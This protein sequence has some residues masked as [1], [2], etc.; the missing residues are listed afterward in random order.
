MWPTRT[1]LFAR[2][3]VAAALAEAAAQPHRLARRLGTRALVLLGVG[4]VV[5]AGVFSSIGELAAG[6]AHRPGAGPAIVVAYIV[7]AI[8]CGFS[9]MAYAEMASVVP[10]AGSAYTYAYV[11]LGKLPAWIIGW[12]LVIEYAIGNI[13]VAQSWAEYFAVLLRHTLGLQ[14]PVWMTTDMQTAAA[15]A[16]IASVAPHV[17]KV[18]VAFNLPAAFVTGVLTLVLVRGIRG[19]ARL[20][21]FLVFGKLL[22]LG[23][24]VVVGAFYVEPAHWQPFAPGG[25]RGIWTAAS[26]A[27]FSYI[28]FDAISTAAEEVNDPRKQLPRAMIIT[29]A[30]CAAIYAL[31]GLVMTGLA[32]A[33]ELG[34]GDPLAHVLLRVHLETLASVMAVGAVF[35]VTAVLLV[36]QMGQPRILMCMA[37]DGLLAP[38]FARVHPKYATPVFGTVVTGVFVA[39]APSFITPSQALELTSIGTLFAFCL[40]SIGVIVLRVSQPAMA[41]P[42][43]CPG[44]P[45]VPGCSALLCLGLM[46]GLPLMTW[47]RFG[48]WLL[49]GLLVFAFY[50]RRQSVPI[51]PPRHQHD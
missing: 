14:L 17:G 5:G 30:L 11:T 3:S 32:P 20:N 19:S 1:S 4:A 36:F 47:L 38:A 9:A 28:G 34:V 43:R 31:T 25:A 35:A 21:S 12:D 48:V 26:L 18:V 10:V 13:Y 49:L 41:R 44:Y 42:F 33:S 8:A 24:F 50:G 22:L 29:L 23:V 37:R 2:K 16:S 6:N 7:T 27:F 39:L 46:C 40:V 15:T 45:W 51:D